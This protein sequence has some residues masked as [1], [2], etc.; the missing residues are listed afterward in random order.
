MPRDGETLELPAVR[1]GRGIRATLFILSLLSLGFVLSERLAPQLALTLE[2]G[3]PELHRFL[4]WG[5]IFD[6]GRGAGVN[7]LFAVFVFVLLYPFARDYERARGG[8]RL[9]AIFAGT[10]VAGGLVA[11]LLPVLMEGPPRPRAEMM[12][13]AAGI[14]AAAAIL[15]PGRRVRT[16]FLLP[17]RRLTAAILTL[18]AIL[19]YLVAVYRTPW[20]CVPTIGA[21]LA[22][23]AG[24][25]VCLVAGRV[26]SA[27]A[28]RWERARAG[29]EE[30]L[31]NEVDAILEKI[32]ASGM[33]SLS[34]TEVRLLRKVSRRFSETRTYRDN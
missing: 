13:G 31:R 30:T 34:R 28:A 20:V 8:F 29:K 12:P 3:F 2:G 10:T 9:L 15:Q 27:A 11:L 17:A 14:V 23:L 25:R 4:T 6:T 24:W 5:L 32:H 16:L 7:L 21:L 1:T 26:G 22:T 19:L 18:G 33:N